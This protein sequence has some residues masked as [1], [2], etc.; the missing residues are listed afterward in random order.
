MRFWP[1]KKPVPPQV[2]PT[3]S[4]IALGNFNLTAQLPNQRTI[5]V[6]GY[7]Y[8]DDDASAL[9]ARLDLYQETIERQRL[10]CEIPELE[11][12]REQMMK[13]LDQAR[14]VLADLEQRQKNGEKLSSQDQLTI[15][16]MRS[17]IGKVNEE[18]HK[19]ETAIAD[20]K[21]KAGVAG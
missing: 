3:D 12:K 10:R 19:G 7:I 6:A 20:A 5:Q 11:A 4:R 18:I 8:S 16:N 1:F 14:E 13:G 2:P 9:N 15:R 17:S 21:R